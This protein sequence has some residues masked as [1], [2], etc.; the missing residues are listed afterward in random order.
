MNILGLNYFFHD[1]TACIVQNGELIVAVEEERLTREKHTSAFPVNAI[2]KCLDIS[3]LSF[4]QIDYI[5]VSIKPGHKKFEKLIYGLKSPQNYKT[6]FKHE[7]L[8]A[9]YRQNQL[10][11]WYNTNWGSKRKKPEIHFIEHHLAHVEGS[12]F[13]SPY[14][15]AAL[16]SL[17]GSGE[18]ATSYLGA[19]E[20]IKTQCFQQSYFPMSLGS[21][22]EAATEFCGFRPN[23]DEGKTMGLAS[24][25]DPDVYASIVNKMVEV[26]DDGSILIDL[27]YF[28]YQYWGHQRCSQKFYK[29]FGP[30]RGRH[31][32][33][34]DNHHNVAAA[35]QKVLEDKAMTL[36]RILKQKTNAQHLVIA[37]GVALNSVMNGRIVRESEFDD[38]YVMPAAGDNG[39]AI[40]AAYCLYNKV[41]KKPRGYVHMNP[42]IGASFSN[43]EI[44]KVLT[45]CKLKADYFDDITEVGAK[46][47]YDGKIIGW[48]QGKTEIG[49][50]ALG[51]RSILANPT[52][53]HM[54]DKINAEVKHR[55]AYR[56]FAPS[57]IKEAKNDFFDLSVEAPFMLKVCNVLRE[58][59][60]TLP[61]ITHVDGTARLQ[62]VS[63]ET[64]S[65]YHELI[66]RFGDLSGVPVVLNTSFNIMGEPVVET[67][68]DAIRCF[69]STGIDVLIIGNYV[70]NK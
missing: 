58:K 23:Y 36:C 7:F 60:D 34:Q 54:K 25:G 18:W 40:G 55:E 19:G 57:A 16:L 62:T 63:N 20:G 51:N 14:E 32:E 15:K 69:F 56:P 28:N 29:T 50:R 53:P 37:G 42:Y 64:N 31:D 68:I 17:D 49:P 2:K 1:S 67:P 5:A 66:R 26:G 46:L 27:S 41:L 48:F 13:V 33:F 30:P 45:E 59:R 11:T 22:Y 43:E 9:R 21:F 47:L 6:F 65:L 24:F 3:G 10:L 35:F 4:E 12:F 39:T 70:V 61:A 44:F 8:G 38:V 52:L